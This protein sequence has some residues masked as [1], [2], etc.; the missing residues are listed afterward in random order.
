MFSMPISAEKIERI[1]FNFR[2]F[3]NIIIVIIIN[4]FDLIIA[5]VVILNNALS[6]H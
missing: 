5:R 2:N 4:I 1:V 3:N 6:N